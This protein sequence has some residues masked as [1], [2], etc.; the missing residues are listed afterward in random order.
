MEDKVFL[1]ASKVFWKRG[2]GTAVSARGSLGDL[3]TLWDTSK[4]DILEE[5]TCMH[6]DLHK[7]SP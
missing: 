7:D 4:Y 3:R 5:E 1:Q 6:M 2:Q